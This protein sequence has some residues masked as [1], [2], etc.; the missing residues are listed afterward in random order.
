VDALL[1]LWPENCE[2]FRVMSSLKKELSIFNPRVG[3]DHTPVLTNPGTR[4]RMFRKLMDQF[5]G[6]HAMPQ[7]QSAIETE[8]CG[9]IQRTF[10]AD[11]T[12]DFFKSFKLWVH[13]LA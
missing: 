2:L 11:G 1:S 7:H 10:T 8:I 12:A 5:V 6:A 9:F 3:F 4:F 13:L